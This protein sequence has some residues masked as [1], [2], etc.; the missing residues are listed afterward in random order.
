MLTLQVM[1][2]ALFSCSSMISDKIHHLHLQD[3]LPAPGHQK[4][5]F[6]LNPFGENILQPPVKRGDDNND[7]KPFPEKQ[8]GP[9]AVFMEE[10]IGN[11]EPREVKQYGPGMLL[12]FYGL[13]F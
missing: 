2:S 11:Y 1:N 7:D 5:N 6:P 10:V 12:I 9:K 8:L 13:F 3:V 4:W